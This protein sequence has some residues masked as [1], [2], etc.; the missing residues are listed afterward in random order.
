MREL[1][2]WLQGCWWTF[3]F[4]FRRRKSTGNGQFANYMSPDSHQTF[5]DIGT[6]YPIHIGTYEWPEDGGEPVRVEE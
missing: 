1:W 3:P 4:K 6:K 5:V 2:W